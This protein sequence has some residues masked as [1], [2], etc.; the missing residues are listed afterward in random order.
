MMHSERLHFDQNAEVYRR[1]R[2]PYPTQLYATLREWG[3]LREGI[4]VLEIGPGS[5]QATR[6][7]LANGIRSIHAVELG[8]TLAQ[9]LQQQL[10]D[11]RLTVTVGDIHRVN[12]PAQ[13][14]DL[15]SS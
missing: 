7:L 1:S 6:A 14:Y 11:P 15:V 2:P 13:A 12:L 8:E 9:E 10:P 3:A 4:D 5:G